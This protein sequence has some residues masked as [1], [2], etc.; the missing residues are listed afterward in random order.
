MLD[1]VAD[2]LRSLVVL[3]VSLTALAQSP[4]TATPG[5]STPAEVHPE[6]GSTTGHDARIKKGCRPYRYDYAITP[7]E[8]YWSLETFLIG[9]RGTEYASGYFLTGEDP[10]AGPG[11]FR[12]CRRALEAG[13]FTI[14]ARVTVGDDFTGY[15]EGWLPDS[16]FRLRPKRH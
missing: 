3:V 11:V 12:L 1:T 4:A 16:T 7:P 15:T 8:G 9:P 2:V 13:R 5:P 14:R 6:W 10:L